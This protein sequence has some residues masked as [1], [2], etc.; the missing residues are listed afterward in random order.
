MTRTISFLFA[1]L[2]EN[3]TEDIPYERKSAIK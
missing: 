2:C 1:I 3:L